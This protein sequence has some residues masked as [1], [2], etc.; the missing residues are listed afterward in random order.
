MRVI[1]IR[2]NPSRRDHLLAELW[3]Q[4]TAG[5][6]EDD[7]HLRAYFPESLQSCPV[8]APEN[9]E[10]VGSLLEE[11]S[12]A[13]HSTEVDSEPVLLGQ[14]FVITS[15]P[16]GDSFPS[17]RIA[18][19]LPFSAAFGSGRHES[20][21]LMVEAMEAYL[22]PGALVIDAG[23]GSGILSDVARHLGASTV[24]ACDIHPQAIQVTRETS[25][26]AAA[27][28]G[29]VDAIASSTADLV[30]ANISAKVIDV[31]AEDLL[32]VAKPDGLL[33]LSGFIQDRT[34]ERF[35]PE[36]ILDRNGW[37]CWICRPELAPGDSRSRPAQP[38]DAQWW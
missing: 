34:P 11:D 31:L 2:P 37:L 21:Q 38:F 17:T 22:Q 13:Y 27:F 19:S 1:I 4:G 8:V 35:R 10:I 20:T 33:L 12:P 5:I 3:E 16:T 29:S 6:L 14:R 30:L 7:S 23:C 9:G 28:L 26:S 18:L 24:V 36:K 25:S 32:R 15:D